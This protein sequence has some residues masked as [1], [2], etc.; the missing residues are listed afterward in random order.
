M[1]HQAAVDAAKADPL[2][3]T[4]MWNCFCEIPQVAP[5][6]GQ[7]VSDCQ[8]A[9]T[10]TTNGWCY[11]DPSTAPVMYQKQE[12]ALV[13]KCPPTEQ[14]NIRFVGNGSPASGATLFI[15]CAGS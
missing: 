1:A 3:M 7:P 8:T 15:T 14:H 6:M 9:M 11:V 13:A 2:D 10:P 5:P 4:A 12:A